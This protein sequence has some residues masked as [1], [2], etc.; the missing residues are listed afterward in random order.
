MNDSI[1]RTTK[2]STHFQGYFRNAC[3]WV[4][5]TG[6]SFGW[7]YGALSEVYFTEEI[8]SV[9]WKK[10]MI[11]R[12]NDWFLLL[13][14]AISVHSTS[15]KWEKLV[16]QHAI[17]R[18]ACLFWFE[19]GE[20]Y[21]PVTE[22]NHFDWMQCIFFLFFRGKGPPIINRRR[23]RSEWKQISVLNW[24]TTGER[25]WWMRTWALF[26]VTFDWSS[27]DQWK[28]SFSNGPRYWR[29]YRAKIS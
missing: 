2:I 21:W 24:I 10:W 3:E 4:F 11:Y 23:W 6:K 12:H 7:F 8:V 20:N 27:S 13:L 18:Y 9:G 25:V 5:K 15:M 14:C 22:K 26:D 19:W 29:F 1:D 17:H 28:S 16:V